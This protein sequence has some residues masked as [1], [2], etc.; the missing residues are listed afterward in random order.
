MEPTVARRLLTPEVAAARLGVS[1]RTLRRWADDDRVDLT[2]HTPIPG[3]PRY[4]ANEVEALRAAIKGS[5][6]AEDGAA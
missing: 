5:P 1:L 6:V 2:V 4:D 3:R